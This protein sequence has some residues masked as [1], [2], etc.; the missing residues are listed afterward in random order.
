MTEHT[1]VY[2]RTERHARTHTHT[3]THTD[4]RTHVDPHKHIRIFY[5]C[6]SVCLSIYLSVYH[7][8]IHP[9]NIILILDSSI[10]RAFLTHKR[11]DYPLHEHYY[12]GTFFNYKQQNKHFSS[13][14]P[15]PDCPAK[16]VWLS[17]CT[18]CTVAPNYT[19]ML[20]KSEVWAKVSCVNV[21]LL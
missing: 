10:I 17:I 3:H 16:S 13:C 15:R 11:R 2:A 20:L 7:P 18:T 8:S 4:K 21:S 19:K 14:S 6:L 9:W 12:T 1:H 5:V